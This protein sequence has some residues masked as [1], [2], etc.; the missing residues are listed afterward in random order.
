MNTRKTIYEKLF[1]NDETQLETHDVKLAKSLKELDD[2][3]KELQ[4]SGEGIAR[5]RT[6]LKDAQIGLNNTG[7]AYNILSDRYKTESAATIKA[8]KDLGVEVPQSVINQIK[9]IDAYKTKAK[10]MFDLSNK[11]EAGLKTL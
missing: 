3:Y 11:I 5:Y 10:Q 6:N 4:K 2:I 7:K 9:F 8:V 1:S